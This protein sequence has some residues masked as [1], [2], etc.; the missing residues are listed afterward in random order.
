MGEVVGSPDFL[1]E[2]KEVLL[3]YMTKD[4][5][6]EVRHRPRK[7][8]EEIKA[9]CIRKMFRELRRHYGLTSERAMAVATELG[10][11][12]EGRATVGSSEY[13]KEVL[14]TLRLIV[15]RKLALLRDD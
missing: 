8:T 5:Q 1:S 6:E 15:T 4:E 14:H 7:N 12:L 13:Q 11:E 2:F 9:K 3:D 10:S